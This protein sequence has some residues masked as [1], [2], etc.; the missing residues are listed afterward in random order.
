MIVIFEPDPPYIRWGIIKKECFSRDRIVFDAPGLKKIRRKIL[1]KSNGEK[2]IFGYVLPNGG[3]KIDKPIKLLTEKLLARM[4]GCIKF[5]PEHNSIIYKTA[6]Y[7]FKEFFNARHVLFCDTSFFIGL[8]KKTSTYAIP[9]KLRKK[10]IRRYGGYGLMH[11][12]AWGQARRVFGKDIKNVV[13]VYIGNFPNVAAIKNAIPVETTIG[14]TSIEGIPSLNAC[15]DIDP[16]I[17]FQ[18]HAQGMSFE[19]INNLLSR[20]SGLNC[21]SDKAC[22]VLR[23]H[24]VRYIGAFISVLGG[25]DAIVFTTDNFEANKNFILRICHFLD[26]LGFKSKIKNNKS[27][28]I[29]LNSGKSKIK[30]LCL[31]YNKWKILSEKAINLVDKEV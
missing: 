6:N 17:V 24:I 16:T 31:H 26:C 1:E 25:V 20:E 11:E 23:Y 14:F 7:L 22:E 19:R 2:I 3:E 27:G 9:Y 29:I 28:A 18:L 8:P 12:W 30:S 4:E 10:G 21:L 5:L 13:S 15:G